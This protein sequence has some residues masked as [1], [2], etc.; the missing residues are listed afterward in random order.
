MTARYVGLPI[1]DH[2]TQAMNQCLSLS[3][4]EEPRALKIVSLHTLFSLFL[5]FCY[6]LFLSATLSIFIFLP[7]FHP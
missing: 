7:L 5:S 2:V 6:L 1:Q 3:G 4:K